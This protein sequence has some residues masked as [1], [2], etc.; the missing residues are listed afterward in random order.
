MK[1]LAVDIHLH[2]W[3]FWNG[4]GF[5]YTIPFQAK[6]PVEGGGVVFVDD[7]AG[8]GNF[9]AGYYVMERA[10]GEQTQVR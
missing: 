3:T 9:S 7:K 6:V 8:H 4:P 10:R 1:S 5:E 2:V